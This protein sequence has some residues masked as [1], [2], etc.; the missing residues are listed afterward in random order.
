MNFIFENLLKTG[1]KVAPSQRSEP[2]IR[3]SF[4][5]GKFICRAKI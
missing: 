2:D 5:V 1:T 4:V 3:A